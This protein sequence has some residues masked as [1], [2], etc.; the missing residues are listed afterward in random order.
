M[1]RKDAAEGNPLEKQPKRR[2][3]HHSKSHLSKNSDNSAGRNNTSADSKANDMD[4]AIEQDEPA[5]V[6]H[7]TEPLPDHG[8]NEGK[9]H[10]PVSG[11]ENSPDDDAHIIR[12]GT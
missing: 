4:P 5:D 1:T 6:E 12:K 8:D 2:H 9:A 10:Q 11:E 3:R 7:S